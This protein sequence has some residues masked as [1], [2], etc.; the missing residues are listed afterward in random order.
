M[1]TQNPSKKKIMETQNDNGQ[2]SQHKTRS[3]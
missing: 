3:I 2:F 1:E